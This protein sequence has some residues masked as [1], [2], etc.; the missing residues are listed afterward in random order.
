MKYYEHIVKY[1]S[2]LIVSTIVGAVARELSVDR[3]YQQDTA[4]IIFLLTVT[5]CIVMYAVI[6]LLL[7]SFLNFTSK[8]NKK[9]IIS[10]AEINAIDFERIDTIRTN[11][12]KVQNDQV[13]VARNAAIKYTEEQFASYVSNEDLTLLCTYVVDYSG[14]KLSKDVRPIKVSN[15]SNLDLYHFGWNIWKH[16]NVSSQKEISVFLKNVFRDALKDVE[17]HSIKRH[18]KDDEMKGIIKIME[19][20]KI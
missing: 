18:L 20:W 12:Q 8:R 11:Q 2:V 3:N 15:L 9:L 6:V 4:N 10:S 19:E 16:F 17:L 1:L 7:D 5:L 13:T 14:N